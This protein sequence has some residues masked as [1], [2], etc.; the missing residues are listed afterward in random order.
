[1]LSI[2]TSSKT[3]GEPIATSS[4][5]TEYVENFNQQIP[6]DHI[7]RRSLEIQ[8]FVSLVSTKPKEIYIKNRK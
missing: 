5:I 4:S 6:H 7:C 1:M 3:N 8:S 2:I